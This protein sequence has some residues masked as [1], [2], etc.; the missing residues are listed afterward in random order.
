[1]GSAV[2]WLN[3][4]EPVVPSALRWFASN[5]LGLLIGTPFLKAVLDG[6]YVRCFRQRSL[7]QRL[8]SMGLMALHAIIVVVVFGQSSLPLLF[9]PISSL[10][11]LSFRMGKLGA[12]AGVIMVAVGGATAGY[13]DVGPIVLIHQDGAFR[14]I[15][16]QVYLGVILCT[17]L[18]V[19][20]T[21]SSL[22]EAL[23]KLAEHRLALQQILAHSPDGV[24]SFDMDGV[25]RWAD[26]RL[27]Q[28]LDL[29]PADLIGRTVEQVAEDSNAKLAALVTRALTGEEGIHVGE[30]EPI[31][32]PGTNLEASL[33]LL[34][35]DTKPSGV[36]VT[37]R[38]ITARKMRETAIV[39][40]AETDDL[41]G[42][43]NRK[44]LRSHLA[45][46]LRQPSGPITLALIDVDHFKAI[47]DKF[48]HS[49]GDAVLREIAARLSAGSRSTDLV[50]RLGGDEF[51][52]AFRCDLAT[53]RMACERIAEAMR[54]TPVFQSGNLAV[55][56]S[57]SCGVAELRKGMSR[58]E[59]FDAADVA[60]YEVKRA[61]RDGV[62]SA[63]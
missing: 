31:G 21:V 51:A 23:K 59:L 6:S 28:Q 35:P 10:L 40:M 60:L 15:F 19:A 12:L 45:M 5:S 57:I 30:F 24:L 13:H 27:Q 46:A 26:G 49:V 52:I 17:T 20:A 2:S 34:G 32:R 33:S 58:G 47:N 55:I 42:V 7:A 16:F 9:L 29:S 18:P 41:T 62:R 36:V 1:M 14:A 61:G 8:E 43:L 3:Y 50:G 56:A 54:A 37:L 25:C 63:T 38:D 22:A 53:A 44:G 48:G 39:R 4:G 11:L